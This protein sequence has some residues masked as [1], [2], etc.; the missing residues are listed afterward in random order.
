MTRERL[1][2]ELSR[3]VRRNKRTKRSQT[4][5]LGRQEEEMFQHNDWFKDGCVTQIV[6]RKVVSRISMEGSSLKKNIS[7]TT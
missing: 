5:E 6:S 4:G 2:K 3:C 7:I 1:L